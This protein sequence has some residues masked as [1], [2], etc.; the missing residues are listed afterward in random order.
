MDFTQLLQNLMQF[1]WDN[2]YTPIYNFVTD[3]A[4]SSSEFFLKNISFGFGNVTWFTCT[5]AD[6]LS[7]ALALFVSI[8]ALVLTIR[9]LKFLS[10][11]VG[12]LFG[13][14]K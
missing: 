9:F 14:V 1:I 2:L 5:V 12:R 7:F 10:K 3:T 4:I 8:T 11:L 13:G 6:L